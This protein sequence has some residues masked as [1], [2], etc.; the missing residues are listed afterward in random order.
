MAITDIRSEVVLIGP[1]RSGKSTL[2]ALLAERFGVPVCSLDRIKWSYFADYG[3]DQEAVRRFQQAHGFLALSRYLKRYAIR[4][5]EQV[6]VEHAGCVFD[7]GAGHSMYEDPEHVAR[8]HR[9]LAPFRNVT[10]VMPSP[11]R[12]ESVS[13]L[14]QRAGPWIPDASER[15][16]FERYEVEHP[17]NR[18]LPAH[19]LYTNG[20]T[21]EQSCDALLRCIG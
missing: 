18:T 7:F 19:R 4:M 13:I 1:H 3:L 5:V 12:E 10:L 14:K 17:S 8:I 9:A 11:D 6:L 16:D 15:F 2:A 21:P 20:H